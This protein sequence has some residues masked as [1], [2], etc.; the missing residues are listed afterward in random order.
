MFS[1]A[2]TSMCTGICRLTRLTG[3]LLVPAALLTLFSGLFSVK[4]FLVPWL[5]YGTIYFIH[6]LVTMVFFVPIFFIHSL[7]GILMLFTRHNFLNRN[8]FKLAAAVLWAGVFLLAGIFYL[9]AAPIGQQMI[10]KDVAAISAGS[11]AGNSGVLLTLQEIAKHSSTGDC[12]LILGGKVYDI[13]SY[14]AAHP[15][16]EQ[17]IISY[18]G[19]DGTSAFA[20]KDVGRPHSANAAVLLQNF[21]VG[22]VGGNYDSNVGLGSAAT[23]GTANFPEEE[24]GDD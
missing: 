20:T 7:G 17:T 22:D 15:G 8:S 4:P 9:Q 14:L 16:G 3:W 2:C 1:N 12:W 5:D 21:Y 11:S 24:Y 10:G 18:C 19:S 23:G 13:T 6:T